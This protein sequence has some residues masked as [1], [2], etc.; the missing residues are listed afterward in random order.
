MAKDLMQRCLEFK[1]VGPKGQVRNLV[2]SL[3]DR[4]E[5]KLQHLPQDAVSIH[6]LFEENGTHKLYRTALTCHIPRHVVAAHEEGRNAGATI[7]EA[8]EEL[9]S[10]LLKRNALRRRKQLRRSSIRK[11]QAERLEESDDGVVR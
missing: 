4:L 5:E 7:R 9:E 11:P 8:F 10:Q 6:V 1:H 2:E 3:I